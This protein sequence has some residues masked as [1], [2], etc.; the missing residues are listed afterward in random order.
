MIMELT[1]EKGS[2]LQQLADKF[3]WDVEKLIEANGGRPCTRLVLEGTGR[4][5]E[6]SSS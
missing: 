2:S 4:I 5:A 3:G 6:E 1:V